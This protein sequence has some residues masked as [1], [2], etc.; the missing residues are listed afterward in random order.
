MSR[1][2]ASSTRHNFFQVLQDQISVSEGEGIYREI[3]SIK[4]A[5]VEYMWS[6][7]MDGKLL[8]VVKIDMYTLKSVLNACVIICFWWVMRLPALHTWLPQGAKR[9]IFLRTVKNRGVFHEFYAR[10]FMN[11]CFIYCDLLAFSF[12]I[13]LVLAYTRGHSHNES[14]ALIGHCFLIPGV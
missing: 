3:C 7:C 5:Q 1:Y 13:A 10:F 12:K 8:W 6:S 11:A 9:L 14:S 4:E 2:L